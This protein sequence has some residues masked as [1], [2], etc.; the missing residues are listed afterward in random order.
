[1]K[2]TLTKWQTPLALLVLLILSFGLLIP[3]LGFYWDDWPVI[4]TG[5]LA[6]AAGYQAF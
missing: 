6:G 4:L 1:M 2:N 3:Q 5:R